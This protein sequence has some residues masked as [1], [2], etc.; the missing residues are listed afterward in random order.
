VLKNRIKQVLM[1]NKKKTIQ[2]EKYIDRIQSLDTAFATIKMQTSNDDLDEIINEL[3]RFHDK[4]NEI[5]KKKF[6][7]ANDVDLL[8][9]KIDKDR[10]NLVEIMARVGSANEDAA[11]DLELKEKKEIMMKRTNI[12]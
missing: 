10:D 4:S 6:S 7:L 9:Q 12:E 1:R 8:Q 3:R 11:N 2:L 5:N